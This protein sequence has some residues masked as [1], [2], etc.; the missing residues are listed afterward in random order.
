MIIKLK[1][2]SMVLLLIYSST[3]YS[4]E[5]SIQG[6]IVKYINEVVYGEC[7]SKPDKNNVYRCNNEK[8]G[9]YF[10]YKNK[11]TKEYPDIKP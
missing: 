4:D 7:D 11:I 9:L 2:L 1:K 8:T 10:K 5:I 3:T 6:K